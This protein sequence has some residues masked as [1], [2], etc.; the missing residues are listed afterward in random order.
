MVHAVRI[1]SY[2]IIYLEKKDTKNIQM[3]FWSMQ[4]IKC[5]AV[6]FNDQIYFAPPT[7]TQT[8]L[9]ECSRGLFAQLRPPIY[10]CIYV[11]NNK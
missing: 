11:Y 1:N 8:H 10:I 3:Q 4:A 2:A 7:R 9:L 6:E 5:A